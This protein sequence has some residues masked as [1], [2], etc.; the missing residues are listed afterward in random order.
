M[1][2]RLHARE[3][4]VARR[5]LGDVVPSDTIVISPDPTGRQPYDEVTLYVSVRDREHAD[6]ARRALATADVKVRAI[7]VRDF[8]PR[9]NFPIS[10]ARHRRGGTVIG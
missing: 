8:T 10:D 2:I 9:R 4:E 5:V 6:R 3:A 1:D 7:S